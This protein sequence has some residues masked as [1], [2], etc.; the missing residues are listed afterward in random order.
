MHLLE[1]TKTKTKRKRKQQNVGIAYSVCK[2][3][4]NRLLTLMISFDQRE[5][6][7]RCRR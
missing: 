7:I 2:L 1:K 5:L 3:E 4:Y 6:N